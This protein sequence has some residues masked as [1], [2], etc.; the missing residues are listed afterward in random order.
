MIL[1]DAVNNIVVSVSTCDRQCHF[2]G[3]RP[4][5]PMNQSL[6]LSI[7]L[8]SDNIFE[9]IEAFGLSITN[10]INGVEFQFGE[11]DFPSTVINIIDRR[12]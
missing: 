7:P 10:D 9:G 5:S 4:F 3:V 12:K 1:Y 8:V 11:S 2:L 6:L